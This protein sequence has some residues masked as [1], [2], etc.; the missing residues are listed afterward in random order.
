MLEILL[1]A[2]GFP[3]PKCL[4]YCY[5][6]STNIEAAKLLTDFIRESAPLTHVVIHRDRDFMLEVELTRVTDSIKSCGA[7]PFITMG[8]DVESYFLEPQHLANRIGVA[9]P[10][11]TNWLDDIAREDHMELQH[12]FTRK[13]DEIKSSMYRDNTKECP[14]TFNLLGKVIPL[15]AGL[16]HGKKMLKRV[17]AGV[18]EK[19]A[20]SREVVA[21]SPFLS[22]PRLKE[23]A[24]L[25]T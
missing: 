23:I 16:R 25:K 2:N 18:K 5:K 12:V 17:R 10:D 3:L 11:V 14:D 21:E 15:P 24:N 9:V 1:Q 22:C 20:V 8:C 13:R 6:T 7:I 19:F 4:F